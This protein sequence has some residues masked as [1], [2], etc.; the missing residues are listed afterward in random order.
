[1]IVL[2]T[3]LP[4]S[5]K[6]LMYDIESCGVCSI[7]TGGIALLR[8]ITMAN[9]TDIVCVCAWLETTA[10]ASLIYTNL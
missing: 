9:H 8:H 6:T 2:C 4:A 10:F 5:M 1:M 3:C 7:H